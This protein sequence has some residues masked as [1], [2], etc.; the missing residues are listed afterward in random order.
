MSVVEGEALILVQKNWGIIN[1]LRV[2][3][4]LIFYNFVSN[5]IMI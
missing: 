5:R 4:R 2:V 1:K 3:I